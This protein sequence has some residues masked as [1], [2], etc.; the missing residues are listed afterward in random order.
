MLLDRVLRLRNGPE[1]V[2]QLRHPLEVVTW[3]GDGLATEGRVLHYLHKIKKDEG[4]PQGE[5][6]SS[7][8]CTMPQTR[9]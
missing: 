3:V 7:S 6:I 4:N 5:G 1:N 2:E 8:L 9:R